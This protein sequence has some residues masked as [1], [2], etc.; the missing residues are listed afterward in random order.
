MR[1]RLSGCIQLVGIQEL[2]CK[3]GEVLGHLFTAQPS[4]C[5]C[6]ERRDCFITSLLLGLF[7]HTPRAG[8]PSEGSRLGGGNWTGGVRMSLLLLVL[9]QQEHPGNPQCRLVRFLLIA[10]WG[11]RTQAGYRLSCPSPMSVQPKRPEHRSERMWLGARTTKY[12][13]GPQA[14][15]LPSVS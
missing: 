3:P 14:P 7:F 4:A 1:G 2:D 12:P 10:S 13:Q 9:G 6:Q 8:L 11:S 15:L 5:G